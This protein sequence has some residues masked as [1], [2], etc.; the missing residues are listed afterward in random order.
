MTEDPTD[1]TSRNR[2][3]LKFAVAGA[4]AYPVLMFVIFLLTKLTGSEWGLDGSSSFSVAYRTSALL[5]SPGAIFMMD[6]EHPKEI[7]IGLPLVTL[8]NV[9]WYAFVGF[10]LW[11]FYVR[12]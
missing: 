8:V 12:E 5:F 2:F 6:A 3:V 10:L 9:L 7:M 11:R 1:R 4:L